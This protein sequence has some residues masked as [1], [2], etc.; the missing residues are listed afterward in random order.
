MTEHYFDKDFKSVSKEKAV[1]CVK[2]TY[3]GD[4]LEEEQIIILKK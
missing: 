4:E 2:C 3:K 1:I